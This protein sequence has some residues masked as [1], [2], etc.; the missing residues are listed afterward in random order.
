MLGKHTLAP[1]EKTELKVTYRTAGMPGFF[2]KRVILTTN[3]P[4]Q[5]NIE[6]FMIKGEVQEAPGAKISVKPRRVTLE[7]T[8]RVNGRKQAF[9][10]TNEGSL[11]LVIDRIHSKDDKT[12]Y[13]DG[14]K[15]GNIVVEPAQ[16]KT[17]ELQL[18][19]NDEEKPEQ[20]YILIDS[21]AKNAGKSGYFLLVQYGAKQ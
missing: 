9:S 6:I 11:P 2:Q 4:G 17:I 15:E 12:V 1:N 8:D 21:N 20:E 19:G 5:E 3:V 14:T 18:Q 7:G 16:T 13:F 10:I